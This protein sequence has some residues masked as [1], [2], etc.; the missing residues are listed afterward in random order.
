MRHSERHPQAGQTIKV[1]IGNG[2]V[3]FR[4]EDWW[5][6]LTGG[7]WMDAVGNPAALNYAM[8]SALTLPIDDEV[9]YGKIGALGYLVHTSEF[10]K[11]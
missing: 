11:G 8:R 4:L 10:V 9:V 1:D 7:S 2:P 3:D 5:D 6:H